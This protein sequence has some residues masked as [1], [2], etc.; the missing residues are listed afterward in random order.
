MH[1]PWLYILWP[2]LQVLPLLSP[3][4]TLSE[5]TSRCATLHAHLFQSSLLLHPCSYRN[6]ATPITPE[7]NTDCN[8]PPRL[9]RQN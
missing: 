3:P 5:L 7:N 6:A 8:T 4:T 9:N 2:S 1:S